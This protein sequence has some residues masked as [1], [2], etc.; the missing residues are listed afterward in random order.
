MR[1]NDPVHLSVQHKDTGL[2]FGNSTW[3]KAA[4]PLV[5]NLSSLLAGVSLKL[6]GGIRSF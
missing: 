4:F 1:L 5:R 2:G 6:S 3:W